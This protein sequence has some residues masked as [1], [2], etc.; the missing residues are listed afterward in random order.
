MY[1]LPEG[2][3]WRFIG[4]LVLGLAVYLSYGYTRSAVGMKMGRPKDAGAAQDRRAWF[5]RGWNGTVPVPPRRL[6][7]ELFGS[8]FELGERTAQS[9]AVWRVIYRDRAVLL[10]IAAW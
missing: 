1:Y 3:Y 5:L 9:L 4:W 10:G 7:R 8:D 2:T 6:L